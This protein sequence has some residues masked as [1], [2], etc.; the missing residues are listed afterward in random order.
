MTIKFLQL[1]RVFQ[2]YLNSENLGDFALLKADALGAKASPDV[3]RKMEAIKEYY[4]AIALSELKQLPPGTFSHEYAAFIKRNQFR[5]INI[6]LKL[7]AITR[8]NV[9]ALRY[10]I[11]HDIFHV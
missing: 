1:Y 8:N 9:F 11:T 3:L 10:A 5:S 6:S 7:A 4:P 2:A